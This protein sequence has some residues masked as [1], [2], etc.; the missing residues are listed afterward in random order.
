M[1]TSEQRTKPIKNEE[2]KLFEKNTII[3]NK[4][5]THLII[6]INLKSL[7]DILQ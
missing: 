2:E 5:L 6:N 3:K 1:V 4:I 7:L